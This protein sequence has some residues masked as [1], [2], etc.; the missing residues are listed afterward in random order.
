MMVFGPISADS[1]RILKRSRYIFRVI[2][3]EPAASICCTTDTSGSGG[4]AIDFF[5]WLCRCTTSTS[6]A[7]GVSHQ[8]CRNFTMAQGHPEILSYA[9][10]YSHPTTAYHLVG[11]H[12][13]CCGA[14]V[15]NM[16]GRLAL[17]LLP[18]IHTTLQLGGCANTGFRRRANDALLFP[19]CSAIG[20]PQPKCRCYA[21]AVGST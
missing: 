21:L 4:I 8:I 2:I 15:A 11:G 7:E 17:I 14:N 16:Q 18:R 1:H 10:G 9:C 19:P 13:F 20:W 6:E 3:R 12:R 5:H